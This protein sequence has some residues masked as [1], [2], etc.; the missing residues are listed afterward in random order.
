MR[1]L[2]YIIFIIFFMVIYILTFLYILTALE[3][4]EID[5]KA[6][7]ER[8]KKKR[9]ETKYI[10]LWNKFWGD[11]LWRQSDI[12][13]EDFLK[14]I[15]CP[16]TRCLVVSNFHH[17]RYFRPIEEYDA[18]VFHAPEMK[19]FHEETLPDQQKRQ[20]DQIY[21]FATQESPRSYWEQMK[22]YGNF[23]NYT[24]TTRFDSDSRWDFF[25]VKWYVES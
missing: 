7:A 25:K 9:D 15:K 5:E 19:P 20:P 4:G 23:F 11:N 6:E 17:I 8:R 16:E 24:I 1:N 12:M 18:I 10:L 13:H 3:E 14:R 21:V 2:K 22:A